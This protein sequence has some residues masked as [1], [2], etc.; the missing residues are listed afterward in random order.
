VTQNTKAKKLMIQVLSM[1]K[2]SLLQNTANA[3]ASWSEPGEPTQHHC[4]EEH[5]LMQYHLDLH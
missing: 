5:K 4:H 3:M 1:M 2:I